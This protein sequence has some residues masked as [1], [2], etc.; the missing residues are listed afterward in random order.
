[1]IIFP[2]RRCC[3]RECTHKGSIVM[4]MLHL[5]RAALT[6]SGSIILNPMT[7]KVLPVMVLIIACPVLDHTAAS[8]MM[9]FV[10]SVAILVPGLYPQA[11]FSRRR[12]VFICSVNER[13]LSMEECS[14]LLEAIFNATADGILV[15]DREGNITHANRQ[16]AEM[17]HIPSET[18]DLGDTMKLIGLILNRMEKPDCFFN[19]IRMIHQSS[20]EGFDEIRLKDGR[21]FE[22]SSCPLINAGREIGRVWDFRDITEKKR[23]ADELR[24]SRAQLQAVLDA[25]RDAITLTDGSGVF[26]AC[27]KALMERWGRSREELIGH[28]AG[29][30]L[31][32]AIFTDRL[33]RVRKTIATGEA[34]HFVDERQGLWFENTIAPIVDD[35][36]YIHTVAMYSRDITERME[37]EKSIQESERRYR[38]LVENANSIILRWNP[39]GEIT[40]MNEFGLRFFGYNKDELLGR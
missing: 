21:I 8:L 12:G 16:L 24:H 7:A 29:E 22:L 3:F 34:D 4:G 2:G 11:V 36:G 30:V 38:E 20:L 13:P 17:W 23:A 25:S 33:E 26:L 32:P 28:S 5:M 6:R 40:F 18:V 9:I 19:R 39:R 10:L 15:V 35:D 31:P 14:E 37:A 1:M 27:N